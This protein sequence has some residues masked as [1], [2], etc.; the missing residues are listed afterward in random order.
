MVVLLGQ[1]LAHVG[2]MAGDGS[3]HR[4]VEQMGAHAPPLPTD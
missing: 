4:R 3:G 1:E 2:E